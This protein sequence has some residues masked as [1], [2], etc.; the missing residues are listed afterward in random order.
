MATGGFER[1]TQLTAQQ[2]QTFLARAA[3][4]PAAAA[5]LRLSEAQRRLW[6]L[7]RLTDGGALYNLPSAHRF[8][9]RFSVPA[10]RRALAELAQRHEMLRMRYV[11]VLGEPLQLPSGAP[12]ECPLVD[13]SGLAAADR[14]A[15]LLRYTEVDARTPFLLAGGPLARASVLRLAQ[16]DHVLLLNLHHSIADGWSLDLLYGELESRY[17]AHLAGEPVPAPPPAAGYP[18]YAARQRDWLDGPE[19][20]R[21][22]AFWR[23]ELASA[24]AGLGLPADPVDPARR[25]GEGAVVSRELSGAVT[26]ALRELGRAEGATLFMVLL[27]AYTAVLRRHTGRADLVVGSPVSGRAQVEWAEVVGLFV[28]TTVFRVRPDGGASFREL[29]SAVR[30]TTLRAYAHQEVP[31]DWLVDRLGVRRESGRNPLFS[32]FLS[33]EGFSERP[34]RLGGLAGEDIE[35]HSATAWFDLSLWIG[36][37]RDGGLR[38]DLTYAADRFAPATAERLADDLV[39]LLGAAADD[40]SAT[41]ESLAPRLREA[42]PEAAAVPEAADVLGAADAASGS[43]TG[44]PPLTALEHTVADTWATLLERP[45][46]YLDDDFFELGGRS[47]VALQA[48]ARLN[49]ICGTDLHPVELFEAPT[50]ESFARLLGESTGPGTGADPGALRTIRPGS[51]PAVLCLPPI[52]GD[53]LCYA[54]LAGALDDD[55]PVYAAA[56]PGLHDD[57]APLRT[58]AELAEHFL[59]LLAAEGVAGPVT[60]VGWSMGGVVAVEM[61]HRLAATGRRPEVVLID[62]PMPGPGDEDADLTAEFSRYLAAAGG[63]TGPAGTTTAECPDDGALWAWA[64]QHGIIGP[65]LDERRFGAMAEVFRTN[66]GLLARPGVPGYDGEVLYLAAEQDAADRRWAP[67]ETA[68]SGGLTVRRVPGDHFSVMTRPRVRRIAE[69]IDTWWKRRPAHGADSAGA[70]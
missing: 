9:G 67:W 51:G 8:R 35:A 63:R 66:V 30:A 68:L 40:P 5:R 25:P 14:E 60:L 58:A 43:R 39:R 69:E 3:A 46:V 70:R 34:V 59:G 41:V 32:A 10:L 56:V 48:V 15:E 57:R 19:A 27:G 6:F 4:N 24:P 53:I 45:E 65:E 31:F 38:I 28:N 64:Q 18:G 49:E 29:L 20:E 26:G 36:E 13:L 22:L 47:L 55:R 52:G 23:T 61:A 54:A 1:F 42:L 2:R 17:D 11:E 37:R 12:L 50:V 62:T 44:R 16:D 7:E 21:S 33:V